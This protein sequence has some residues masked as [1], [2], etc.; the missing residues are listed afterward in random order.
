[1]ATVQAL[2]VLIVGLSA[3]VD[4]SVK[5]RDGVDIRYHAEGRGEPAV[6]LVHCW[7]GDRRF[8]DA[9]VPGLARARRVVALDLAGHGESGASR[10]TWTIEAFAD[11]VVAVVDALKLRRVV[12]VGH[13]MGGHV[14]LAAA[15][16]LGGRVAGLVPVDTLLDVEAPMSMAQI[17]EYLRP[18]ER[19]YPAA[20]EAFVRG[21]MFVP[22]SP[23]AVIE[24]VVAKARAAPKAMAIE[25]VRRTWSYDAARAFEVVRA[26]IH[27]INGEKYPTNVEGNRRHAPQYQVTLFPGTGHY[28]MLE[29]PERFGDVLEATLRAVLAAP[30]RR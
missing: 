10:G 18:F 12:L 30:T 26:P 28:P 13:S 1:M 25:A 9:Q 8:W 2:L 15:Q 5:S 27:A 11:D 19:D 22:A 3:P 23:P 14:T 24:S 6:V 4:A 7:T 29:A 16:R 17:D 20:A 21:Y